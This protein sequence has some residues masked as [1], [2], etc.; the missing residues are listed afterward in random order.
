MIILDEAARVHDDLIAALRPM[1]ATVDGSLIALIDA[2][3]QARL[4][5]RAWTATR[6]GTRPG[7]GSECPRS[8]KAFLAEERRELGPMRLLAKST[9]WPSLSPTR[10][11]HDGTD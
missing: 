6:A 3:R 8:R 11:I 1:M 9:N 10:H 7:A 2:V 4:V 5:L